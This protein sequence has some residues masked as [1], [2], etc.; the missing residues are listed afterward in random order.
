MRRV[1]TVVLPNEALNAAYLF[2]ADVSTDRG[3]LSHVL[4]ALKLPGN[5]DERICF[6]FY[7]TIQQA[8][9]LQGVRVF[10]VAG[11]YKVSDVSCEIR[12]N[13]VWG[14]GIS[15]GSKDGI[16]FLST[17]QGSPAELH[18]V[19]KMG[20]G[21]GKHLVRGVFRL[22]DCPV[23]NAASIIR[24]SY[25]GN[26]RVRRVVAPTFA[27]ETGVR[28]MFKYHYDST[29]NATNDTTI[30]SSHLTAEFKALG[31]V[32]SNSFEEV[33][34]DLDR[35]LRLASFAARYR[36]VC[37]RWSYSD[38]GSSYVDHYYQNIVI[39]TGRVSSSNET[40]IDVATFSRFIRRAYRFYSRST[41]TDLLDS[42]IFALVN[43]R[44]SLEDRFTRVFSGLQ[45]LLWFVYRSDGGTDKR[46]PI[47]KLFGIFNTRYNPK[48][49]DLWPLFDDSAGASLYTIRN[50]IAHGEF[51]NPG[52]LL[53]ATL[54]QEH[55]RWTVERIL[56]TIIG[57]PIEQSKVKPES[58]LHW[59]AAHSWVSV[60]SQ[61]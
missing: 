23:V 30:T 4:C 51:L 40:L 58:L 15:N 8:Q 60:R 17:F 3:A 26:V 48:L 46:V 1:K 42:A 38:D 53:A 10:G 56:L 25:T 16:R 11:K 28:L 9:G 31:R 36:C 39:P 20:K 18:I 57:W 22:T 45:S 44:A 21:R 37:T 7:P 61:W 35:F 5:N 14:S 12:A 24:R 19:K 50:A 47:K 49:E 32:S 6:D 55:L 41:E 27:L 52:K 2:H 34:Q 54:A 33:K 43:E 13:E 59:D 29:E